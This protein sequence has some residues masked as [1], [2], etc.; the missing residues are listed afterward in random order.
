M[1]RLKPIIGSCLAKP[2]LTKS[3]LQVTAL[4]H[5]FGPTN[6]LKDIDFCLEQ[7][8]VVA[9]VGP[10]GC[11]KTTLLHLCAKL[12]AVNDG[13]VDNTFNSF[14]IAFQEP[15]LL[16]WQ[17]ALDNIAFGLKAK[18]INKKQRYQQAV[19]ISKVFGLTPH[20]LD[21]YPKDLSGGMR[22]RVAFARAMVTKPELLFLDEPFSALDIGLKQELQQILVQHVTKKNTT[23]LF[24]THDLMEAVRLSD[25]ILL[26]ANSPGSIVHRLTLDT[27]IINRD[28]QF[29]YHETAK[30]LAQPKVIQTFELSMNLNTA[31]EHE[32]S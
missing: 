2:P 22:Q 15:R 24:I 8:K 14:A 21:K 17:T 16:P 27:P 26:L 11:G 12:L 32:I 19:S 20:D 10:S 25:E 31:V 4:N 9:I 28:D 1:E 6:I 3:H 13:I 18:G 29:V 23:I 5:S 30:L 7:G